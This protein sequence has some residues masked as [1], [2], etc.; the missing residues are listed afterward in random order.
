MFDSTLCKIFR[1]KE[2]TLADLLFPVFVLIGI[3]LLY[4]ADP[5][6][7]IVIEITLIV[8]IVPVLTFYILWWSLSIKIAECKVKKE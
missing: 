3:A 6:S 4:L 2:V 5:K 8:F 1:K 7:L